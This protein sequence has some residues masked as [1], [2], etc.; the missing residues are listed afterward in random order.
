MVIDM[1]FCS[2]CGKDLPE[3]AY[4]CPACGARTGKGAEANVPMPYGDMLSGIARY[5]AQKTMQF[6][7]NVNANAIVLAVANRNGPINASTWDQP[8]YRIDLTI[9]AKGYTDIEAQSII[10]SL[11][12]SVTEQRV[13]NTL[14][15]VLNYDFP[16]ILWKNLT[17]EVTAR[18]PTSA[19]ISLDLKSSNGSI[20]LTN[21]NGDSIDTKT[22]N[23]QLVLNN[24][25]A[26]NIKGSSSN[27]A[28]TGEIEAVSAVLS[29]SNGKIELTIPCK[30]SS[31]YNLETSNGQVAL[32]VSSSS[33]AAYDLDL[34]TSNGVVTINLTAL[35]YTKNERTSKI[36]K[37]TGFKDQNVQVLIRGKTS[38]GNI[39]IGP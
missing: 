27:G 20:Y 24:V 9:K 30:K 37:T 34:S 14:K 15:I 33:N 35:E 39:K 26:N 8:G 3:N 38:N 31:D 4:F 29:T 21:I 10:D 11:K 32:T 2:K 16:D 36:A 6:E 17:I 5:R 12:I 25:Y 13:E 18:L 7:G 23:G 1:V 19:L 28:I 22:S